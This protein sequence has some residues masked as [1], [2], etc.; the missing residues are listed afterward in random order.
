[1]ETLQ[2]GDKLKAK[3]ELASGGAHQAQMLSF[4]VH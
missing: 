2:M 4:G 3:P 1:M